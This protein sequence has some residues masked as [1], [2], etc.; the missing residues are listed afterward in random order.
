MGAENSRNN[1]TIVANNELFF[2]EVETLLKEGKKVTFR[3]KGGSMRPFLRDGDVIR[4]VQKPYDQLRPGD[5]ALAHTDL[6]VL[7]HRIVAINGE[8]VHLL[9][10][11]NRQQELTERRKVMGVFDAAWRGEK[12]LHLN[13]VTM[14]TLAL[15]WY[16]IRPLRRYLLGA[17]EIC[18][19]LRKGNI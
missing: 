12:S 8:Q 11:A 15:Y 2:Q 7:L 14:R 6:G 1:G 3:L 4:I 13:S 10:D 9:G 19:R 18:R 16:K 17:Y 5:I